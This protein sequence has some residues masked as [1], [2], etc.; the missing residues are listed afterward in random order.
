MAV[1]AALAGPRAAAIVRFALVVRDAGLGIILTVGRVALV[2]GGCAVSSTA[3]AV[4]A[5]ATRHAG[6]VI[7]ARILSPALVE[8]VDTAA[9]PA[10]TVRVVVAGLEVILLVITGAVLAV[11]AGSAVRV[12]DA[13]ALTPIT[14]IAGTVAIIDTG[15]IVAPRVVG[16]ALPVSNPTVLRAF[17]VAPRVIFTVTKIRTWVL[18][19]AV[20]VAEFA[21]GA[22]TVAVTGAGSRVEPAGT[23]ARGTVIVVVAC[24]SDAR[25]PRAVAIASPTVPTGAF[26]TIVTFAAVG[27][28]VPT[29]GSVTIPTASAAIV[30]AA[31]GQPTAIVGG[32]LA[33]HQTVLAIG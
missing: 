9:L 6:A 23:A 11:L 5:V 31:A 26:G 24:A 25:G 15:L 4:I 33:V 19:R 17:S 21:P 30:I 1:R 7:T 18:A 3:A 8:E 10:P 32:A 29:V 27:F 14:V 22:V 12:V 20:V 28:L 2:I 16:V 13:V